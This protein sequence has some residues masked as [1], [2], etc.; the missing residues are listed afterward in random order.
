MPFKD[1]VQLL[2]FQRG[3]MPALKTEKPWAEWLGEWSSRPESR[4]EDGSFSMPA[5]LHWGKAFTIDL[6]CGSHGRECQALKEEY[7]QHKDTGR[8]PIDPVSVFLGF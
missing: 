7:D 4:E 5:R 6:A 2:V 3:S 8:L 1:Q